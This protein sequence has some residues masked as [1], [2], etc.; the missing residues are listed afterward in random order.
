MSPEFA[1][2]TLH[3]VV[4][5]GRFGEVFAYDDQTGTFSL[6]NPT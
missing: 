5:W 1:G 3:A 2:D 4:A 6:E